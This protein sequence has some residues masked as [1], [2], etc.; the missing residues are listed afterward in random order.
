MNLTTV[1]QLKERLEAYRVGHLELDALQGRVA[2]DLGGMAAD[3]SPAEVKI[4]LMEKKMAELSAMYQ[5]V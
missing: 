5:Q 4:Q 2:M 3:Q 1:T